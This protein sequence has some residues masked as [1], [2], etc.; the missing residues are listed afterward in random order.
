MG[1]PSPPNEVILGCARCFG[2][3]GPLGLVQPRYID[4]AISGCRPAPFASQPG[5]LLGNG[6]YRLE[7]AGN[8]VYRL[9]T[10]TFI[11]F[12]DWSPTVTRISFA[13]GL[14]T[15]TTFITQPG[16]LCQTHVLGNTF[17]FAFR[18]SVDGV[19]DISW[20]TE[21]L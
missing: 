19:A 17:D 8:C 6:K 5:A 21:G 16:V 10:D 20:P 12:V 15:P 9:V 7:T 13:S 2:I 18:V 11:T 4:L 1:T 3:G 14:W